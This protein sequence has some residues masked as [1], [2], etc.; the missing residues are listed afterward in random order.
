MDYSKKVKFM[1]KV[2]FI[3]LLL[4]WCTGN[5]ASSITV[6]KKPPSQQDCGDPES[7]KSWLVFTFVSHVVIVS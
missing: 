5:V 4:I 7:P 2:M 3:M 1:V 6:S